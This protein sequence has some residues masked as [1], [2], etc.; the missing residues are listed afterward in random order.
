MASVHHNT[1]QSNSQNKHVCLKH[2]AIRRVKPPSPQKRTT[3]EE[4]QQYNEDYEK[5]NVRE[6]MMMAGRLRGPG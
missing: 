6:D 3:P 2:V 5:I 4:I 1:F